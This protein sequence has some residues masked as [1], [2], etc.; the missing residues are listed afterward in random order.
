MR[1]LFFFTKNISFFRIFGKLF[2]YIFIN[3]QFS[4]LFLYETIYFFSYFL[5]VSYSISFV[6]GIEILTNFILGNFNICALVFFGGKFIFGKI[7]LRPF[8]GPFLGTKFLGIFVELNPTKFCVMSNEFEKYSNFEISVKSEFF[9]NIT[10]Y[11]SNF[12]YKLAYFP[13]YSAHSR[14]YPY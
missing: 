4:C 2:L 9:L 8:W 5:K 13:I 10:K 12:R 1:H 6:K 7:I 14:N 3:F 11:F